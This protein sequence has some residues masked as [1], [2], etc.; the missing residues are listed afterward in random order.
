MPILR[1]KKLK[2]KKF[3]EIGN[4]MHHEAKQLMNTVNK[5]FEIKRQ[6]ELDQGTSFVGGATLHNKKFDKQIKKII[7][8]VMKV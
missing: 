3:F 2:G 7:K 4:N 5:N 1:E 6:K 8:N